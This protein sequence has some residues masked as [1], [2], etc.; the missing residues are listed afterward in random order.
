M[1]LHGFCVS[2]A[3][4]G[5]SVRMLVRGSVNMKAACLGGKLGFALQTTMTAIIRLYR[6]WLVSGPAFVQ[7]SYPTLYQKHI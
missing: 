2:Y 5:Q 7:S 3:G 1:V 4:H 6:K